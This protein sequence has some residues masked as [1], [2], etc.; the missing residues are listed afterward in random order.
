MS[1]KYRVGTY[2]VGGTLR[3]FLLRVPPRLDYDI[4]LV[5]GVAG[6]FSQ[7]LSEAVGGSLFPL[8][9]SADIYR[10]VKK[11]GRGLVRIDIS[12]C[13]GRSITDDLKLRDFSINAMA[14]SVAD[15]FGSGN[16]ELIDPFGGRKDLEAGLL[17][18]VTGHVFD[19]DPLR[20]LRAVRFA[21]RYDMRLEQGVKDLIR[22]R[23]VLIERVS[24]ERIRDELFMI[25][26]CRSAAKSFR[27]L[28]DL[29][30]LGN[31]LPETRDWGKV[32]SLGEYDLMTHAIKTL[33]E[34]ESLI[35]GVSALMPSIE[36]RIRE[37]FD[38]KMGN[39]AKRELFLFTAFLHDIGKPATVIYDGD[40]L[41]FLNHDLAGA[42]MA[43]EVAV[44]LR[45]SRKVQDMLHT[46][47][48]YHHRAFNLKRI[49]KMSNR[50]RDHFFRDLGA[51]NGVDALLLA[52]SD[53]RATRG[54]EDSKLASLVKDMVLYR[55]SGFPLKKMKPLL[56]G[57][58]VMEIFGIPQG[59]MIG[60]ALDV[61]A[62][63]EV[64]GCVYTREEALEFLKGWFRRKGAC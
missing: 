4:V 58:D 2:L 20:S 47:I 13:R 42:W 55:Y 8:D 27:L 21:A 59:E 5:N 46:V 30:I 25:L 9:R 37:H 62:R 50:I 6:G 14:V 29:N 64:S 52:L 1:N 35:D 18:V 63:A 31:I 12:P 57:R 32:G 44:G 51:D 33:N 38:E 61:L 39:I 16:P 60:R 43:G 17:R 22:K 54:C 53:A 10:I 7:A 24:R 41:R 28:A 34:A 48:R 26:S 45:L 56:N 19:D 3:D 36:E 23:A 49:K 15:L 11:T 40:R